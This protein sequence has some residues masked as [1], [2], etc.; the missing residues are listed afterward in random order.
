MEIGQNRPRVFWPKQR[1]S[2]YQS[3]DWYRKRKSERKGKK[4]SI[5][6]F[7]KSREEK[8]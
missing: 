2:S 4:D 3:N 7:K 6:R 8:R 5:S 1:K